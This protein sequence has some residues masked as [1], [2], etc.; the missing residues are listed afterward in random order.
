M[1]ARVSDPEEVRA[2]FRDDPFGVTVPA[3]AYE[4]IAETG[5]MLRGHFELMSGAH[6]AHFL[7]FSQIG[8]DAKR[9]QSVAQWLIARSPWLQEV[10]KPITV[11]CSEAAAAFL[12]GALSR[13]LKAS[14]AVTRVD[15]KKRP[16]ASL[17]VGTLEPGTRVVL[18]TDVV[19]TCVSLEALRAFAAEQGIEIVGI[20]A[21]AVLGRDALEKWIAEHAIPRAG[22]LLQANWPTTDVASCELCKTDKRDSAFPAYELA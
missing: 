21:F 9:A 20:L 2:L 13:E 3:A 15:T 8:W 10:K 1:R 14:L 16:Q 4:L 11:L 5:A 18:T 17:R 22:F 12:G 7:R 19:S 6:S